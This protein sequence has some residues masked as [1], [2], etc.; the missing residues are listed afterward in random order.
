MSIV[1]IKNSAVKVIIAATLTLAV[2]FSMG[3]W[4]DITGM[5]GVSTAQAGCL[6]NGSGTGG[7]C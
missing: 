1:S 6:G 3:A 4:E 5:S 2:T 7:G